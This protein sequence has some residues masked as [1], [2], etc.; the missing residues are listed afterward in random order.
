MTAFIINNE[1]PTQAMAPAVVVVAVRPEMPAVV[2]D[3]L[4][5]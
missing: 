2:E 5:S 3:T 1:Q 4:F